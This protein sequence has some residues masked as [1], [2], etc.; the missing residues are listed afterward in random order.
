MIRIIGGDKKGARL[1][2]PKGN[3]T[4][5]TQEKLRKA[6]FD[7]LQFSIEG[8]AFLDLFAG[9]GAIGIE[10]L[11]RG[12][13]S[14]TFIDKDLKAIQCV[15][16]NLTQCGFTATVKRCDAVKGLLS[17]EGPFDYI[18]IDPPYPIAGAVLPKIVATIQSHNLLSPD[19]KIFIEYGSKETTEIESSLKEVTV[20]KKRVFGGT[21]LLQTFFPS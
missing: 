3:T 21:T 18:Y 13:T 19:G 9:S 8:S 5:P 4:R 14:C 10:A 15:K 1:K 12:A 20:E 17:L 7:I 16:E 2:T 11:S 6:L